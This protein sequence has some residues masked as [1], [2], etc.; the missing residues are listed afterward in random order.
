MCVY[1][2]AEAGTWRHVPRG[3]VYEEVWAL[4]V[5]ADWHTQHALHVA[6]WHRVVG[7]GPP[8]IK[9]IHVHRLHPWRPGRRMG[10]T[11]TAARR[12]LLRL[13]LNHLKVILATKLGVS[14]VP[15]ME[16]KVYFPQ[17]QEM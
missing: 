10:G 12:F 1:P 3:G 4:Q 8:R 5:G 16:S 2:R 7:G 17:R 9:R 14:R 13:P 15:S 6:E 11:R